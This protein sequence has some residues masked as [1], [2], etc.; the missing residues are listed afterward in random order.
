QYGEMEDGARSWHNLDTSNT[1]PW[2]GE[3]S[4]IVAEYYYQDTDPAKTMK[5]CVLVPDKVLSKGVHHGNVMPIVR[6]VG[7]EFENEGKERRR[8]MITGSSM[9]AQRAYN[10]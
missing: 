6:T 8:G 4:I 2:I 10:Y 5:W 9:D 1:L 7:E 3:D